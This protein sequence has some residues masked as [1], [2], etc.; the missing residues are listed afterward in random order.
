MDIINRTD[1]IAAIR[2]RLLELTDADHSMCRVAAERGILCRGF[3]QF[4]D[5]ELRDHYAW[6]LRRNPTMSREELEELANRWQLAREIVDKVP[7]SCDAQA[8]EHDICHGWDGFDNATLGRY[9]QQMTGHEARV[10]G[11]TDVH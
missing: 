1:A 2:A 10:V 6:L 3:A 7:I 5:A 11:T 9:Y 8:R 4:N